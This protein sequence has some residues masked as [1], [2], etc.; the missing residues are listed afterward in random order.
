MS[1]KSPV[2]QAL[3][4]FVYAPLGLV[5]SA[6]EELPRLAEKGR[7]QATMAR[8]V[9]QF[10]VAQGRREAEKAMG[11]VGERLAEVVGDFLGSPAPRPAPSAPQT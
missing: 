7:A 11:G 1:D 5:L 3:D 8:M 2:E 9:G 10:V 4:L 6:G